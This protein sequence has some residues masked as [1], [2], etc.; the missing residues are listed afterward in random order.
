MCRAR[1]DARWKIHFIISCAFLEFLFYNLRR[2]RRTENSTP[3]PG[4]KR[5]AGVAASRRK[6]SAQEAGGAWWDVA[7]PEASARAEVRAAYAGA[8]ASQAMG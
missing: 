5:Y 8:R 4:R 2:F 3:G 1:V 7:V 6:V